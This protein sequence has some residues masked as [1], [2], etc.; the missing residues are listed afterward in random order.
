MASKDTFIS[1]GNS[2][3]IIA[4]LLNFCIEIQDYMTGGLDYSY[5][6]LDW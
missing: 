4:C 3:Y 6:E 1:W 2:S 5:I